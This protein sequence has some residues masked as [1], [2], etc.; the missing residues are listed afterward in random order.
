M[1][2]HIRDVR[3]RE[4]ATAYHAVLKAQEKCAE[5]WKWTKDDPRY[6]KDA[7][8]GCLTS[9]EDVR[10]VLQVVGKDLW[11]LDPEQLDSYL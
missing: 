7:F 8:S 6:Y 9:L 11:N 4:L 5:L 2:K 10:G 3:R 1:P